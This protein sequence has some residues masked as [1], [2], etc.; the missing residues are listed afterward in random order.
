MKGILQYCE[1][2]IVSADVVGNP[3]SAVFDA[4]ATMVIGKNLV[5]VFAWYDNEWAFSVRM[6]ETIQ[7]MMAG[8]IG[9]KTQRIATAAAR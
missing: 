7:L 2:P 6:V 1:D 3:Y 9:E 8:A 5:K 4:Q